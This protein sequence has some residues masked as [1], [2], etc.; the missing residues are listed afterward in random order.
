M[1][2]YA[3]FPSVDFTEVLLTEIKVEK[4][5]TFAEVDEYLQ[6]CSKKRFSDVATETLSEK[7]RRCC[8]IL[9][10][11]AWHASNYFFNFRSIVERVLVNEGQ[12][13]GHSCSLS[14]D[15]TVRLQICFGR[16]FRK[17]PCGGSNDNSQLDF[18]SVPL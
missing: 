11:K 13:V 12:K 5:L 16:A 4:N 6:E 15:V 9:K 14:S 3:F 17:H 10:M 1:Q 7:L 18:L 2:Y 8:L